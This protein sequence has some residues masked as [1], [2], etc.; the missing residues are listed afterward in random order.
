M[1]RLNSRCVGIKEFSEMLGVRKNEKE[2]ITLH[3]NGRLIEA[4]IR[5]N[6]SDPTCGHPGFGLHAYFLCAVYK[7]PEL[8]L[9]SEVSEGNVIS[10]IIGD[11]KIVFYDHH[12][13]D[14]VT[15]LLAEP[16]EKFELFITFF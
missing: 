16:F 6:G 15:V 1:R 11:E 5:S 14:R 7:Y 9:F 12:G 10:T 4:Q 3:N 13:C 2:V 8:T